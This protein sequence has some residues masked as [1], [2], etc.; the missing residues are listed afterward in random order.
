MLRLLTGVIAI[1]HGAARQQLRLRMLRFPLLLQLSE[2]SDQPVRL[3][4]IE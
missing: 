3:L 1:E 2:R 4:H